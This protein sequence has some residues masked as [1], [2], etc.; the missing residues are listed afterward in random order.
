[1]NTTIGGLPIPE[2]QYARSGDVQIAYQ[3]YGR[4]T[5]RVLGVPGAVSNI[6]LQWEWVPFHPWLERVAEFGDIVQF[7]KRGMGLSD[8]ISGAAT[9]EERVD[10]LQA[11]MDAVGW[12]DATI[13]AISE[14]GPMAIFYAATHPGRVTS[15]ALTGTFARL[16]AAPD[17]DAGLPPAVLEQLFDGWARSWGTPD[18]MTIPLMVPSCQ[19]DAEFLRFMSRFERLSSTPQ[20]LRDT[21]DLVAEI[22]VRHLLDA[23][24]V[25]TIVFHTRQDNAVPVGH[26]RYLA[27]HIPGAQ[28]VEYDGEHFPFYV[29]IEQH[30]G[31]W[32]QFLTG[33]QHAGP[34]DRFLATVVFTD[35]C[36]ST[37]QA[38][39]AGDD[40]WRRL[41]DRHDTGA[42]RVIE[43]HRGVSVK[44][45]GD[46]V[47][48]TFDSPARAIRAAREMVSSARDLGLDIRAGVHT[49]E[50]ERRGADV[51]GIAVH[52]GARVAGVAG[53]GEV[54]VSAAVPPLVLGSGIEFTDK[55]EFTLKGV[56]EPWRLFAAA[57]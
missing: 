48:A 38:S 40:A 21:L 7:D 11:V 1:V 22:D 26:G 54:L 47:L 9:L 33:E 25:P 29:N 8:R 20:N 46:G 12:E 15:L 23:I 2:T 42:R 16:K 39:A 51:A 35:I 52:I 3:R 27:E 34:D 5:Q 41:L 45:T 44:S 50:V 14:G 37:D 19:G 55:G 28:Y 18:T 10:D 24:R 6:E 56:T 36:G 17:Y 13:W 53:P 31:P 32:E 30:L 57:G 43:Y 4:G 49:G